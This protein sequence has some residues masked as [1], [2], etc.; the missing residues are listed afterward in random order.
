MSTIH[1]QHK[2]N[3]D[4]PKNRAVDT[5]RWRGRLAHWFV[6]N[7]HQLSFLPSSGL[8]AFIV[9]LQI[10]SVPLMSHSPLTG[11]T[12]GFGGTP[13]VHLAGQGKKSKWKDSGGSEKRYW[14]RD[15]VLPAI[16]SAAFHNVSCWFNNIQFGLFKKKT[17]EVEI[18]WS[19][20]LSEY[21]GWAGM[22][23]LLSAADV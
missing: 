4:G 15:G 17:V 11:V 6:M 2:P 13:A 18:K 22:Q 21:R 14:H 16:K 8:K 19:G 20:S 1:H 7:I 23:V 10:I 5:S 3:E 9:E 12:G